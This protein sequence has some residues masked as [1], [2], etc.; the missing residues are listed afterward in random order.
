MNKKL[1]DHIDGLIKYLSRPE[2][3]ANEDM[4]IGFF[5]KE[6]GKEF[7]RQS[8]AKRA[9]GYVPGVFVLE[10]KGKTLDWF[11]GL[12]QGLAYNRDLDFSQV[13]VGAKEF[14]SVWPIENIPNEIVE[15][16]RT[17][18]S[19]PST[20]GKTL[21]KKYKHKKKKILES[22][23]WALRPELVSGELF[24]NPRQITSE[25]NHFINTLKSGKRIRR[26]ITPSNFPDVLKQMVQFFEP[27]EP[28]K[29]VRAFYSLIFD[30]N[31]ASKVV[32]SSKSH[33]KVTFGGY[34]KYPTSN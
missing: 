2:E 25:L 29:A 22:A 19:A 27:N 31:E 14:L 15:D 21:A 17:A 33:D 6:F 5:R 24:S 11:S 4:A 13:I 12:I 23:S 28:L 10:L 9:D 32:I 18:K 1:P 26:K 3:K 20:I 7:T 16:A 30:W 8:D 34:T